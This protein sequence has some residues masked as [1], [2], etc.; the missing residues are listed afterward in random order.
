MSV[1]CTLLTT[2]SEDF[3]GNLRLLTLQVPLLQHL[4]PVYE[5]SPPHCPYRAAQAGPLV[6]E[7]VGG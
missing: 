3:S 2:T 1:R 5:L 6:G 4:G 7:V